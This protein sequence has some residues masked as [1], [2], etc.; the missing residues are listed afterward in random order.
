[1]AEHGPQQAAEADASTSD[2][3]PTL[4]AEL[5]CQRAGD[6]DSSLRD[7]TLRY[8]ALHAETGMAGGPVHPETRAA[9]GV[10]G[11]GSICAPRR[12]RPATPRRQEPPFRRGL[13][14]KVRQ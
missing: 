8:P 11:S 14:Q 6:R 1:M 5:E 9:D 12:Q 4:Q 7:R 2:P 3:A 13:P 10:L